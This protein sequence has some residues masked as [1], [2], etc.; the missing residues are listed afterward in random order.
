MVIF[1]IVF[2]C[3]CRFSQS[4]ETLEQP[5]TYHL[6][7]SES[8][9]EQLLNNFLKEYQ[10]KYDTLQ[11]VFLS[12]SDDS[13][14]RTLSNES[15]IN[16]RF[17]EVPFVCDNIPWKLQIT[18]GEYGVFYG[19][20]VMLLR[21]SSSTISRKNPM[22]SITIR[23]YQNDYLFSEQ[24]TKQHG[25]SIYV[26]M[27]SPLNATYQTE[28]CIEFKQAQ[29][30]ESLLKG[31]RQMGIPQKQYE[32]YHN[33]IYLYFNYSRTNSDSN[34]SETKETLEQKNTLARY[35][36]LTK[37]L[38]S[39]TEKL[40]YLCQYEPVFLQYMISFICDIVPPEGR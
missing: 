31:F 25:I 6:G 19:Y 8:A 16:A 2:L 24:T 14:R 13:K 17:L 20:Q 35:H 4:H 39:E 27:D 22:Y 9:K 1:L 21:E 5:A 33:K 37:F 7:L 12:H 34:F 29:V 30:R 32:V 10:L 3:I 23:Q 18:S 40:L 11:N 15:T 26:L 38:S 28:L 36:T